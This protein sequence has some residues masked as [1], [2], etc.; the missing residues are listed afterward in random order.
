MTISKYQAFIKT[1]ELGSLTK[2]ARALNY[3]QSAVSHMINDLEKDWQI[4]LLDRDRGGVAITSDGARVL[5]LLRRIC[6]TEQI[7]LEE[8]KEIRGLKSGLIR[9]GIFS[10]VATHWLP[11]II[12]RFQEDNPNI[13]FELLLGDYEEIEGWIHE[14]R[15]DCG[16]LCLPAKG[17]LES[18]FL[19][20]DRLLAVVPREHR[21]AKRKRFPLAALCESPFMLLEKGGKSE[22]TGIFDKHRL[23]P[24]IHFTTWDD[25]A[26][27]AM[28]E[29]G[30]GISILPELILRRAPYDIKAIELESPAFRKIGFV[31]RELN[32]ASPAVKCFMN[33]LQFRDAG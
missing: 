32:R 25:Y 4:R 23:N 26:I 8:V 16:F 19:A 10:S 3:T 7:L 29:K 15:V 9:I 12:T 27:M 11:N 1:V 18:V 30:L 5:P 14:G 33:Y 17:K 24:K 13:D 2:A 21:L 6:E 22:I 20:R 31:M 28:V